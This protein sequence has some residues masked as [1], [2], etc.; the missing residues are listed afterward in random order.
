MITV[1]TRKGDNTK[2][3][4]K[5]FCVYVVKNAFNYLISFDFYKHYHLQQIYKESTKLLRRSQF[6]IAAYPEK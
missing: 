5:M 4:L 1:R 6:S 3:H 2:F